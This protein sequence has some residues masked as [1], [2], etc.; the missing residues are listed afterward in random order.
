MQ[1]VSLFRQYS[2]DGTDS[3]LASVVQML[4]ILLIVLVLPFLQW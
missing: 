3:V 4:E 1:I 2:G